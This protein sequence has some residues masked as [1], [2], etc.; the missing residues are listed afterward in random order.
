MTKTR[1]GPDTTLHFISKYQTMR[2]MAP[3]GLF[4]LWHL[5]SHSHE[6]WELK[7]IFLELNHFSTQHFLGPKDLRSKP[8]PSLQFGV[9]CDPVGQ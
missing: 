8:T 5:M 6:S 2:H 4:F 1:Q 3:T 9:A 7:R